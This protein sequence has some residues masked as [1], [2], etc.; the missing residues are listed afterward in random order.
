[1][2][3]DARE[4]APGIVLE[5]DICI[6]G[7]GPAGIVLACELDRSGLSVL[8]LEAGGKRFDRAAEA[9]LHGE[10]AEDCIHCPPQMYRRRVLGGA[11]SIWGGRCVP[12]DPLDL[13][14]RPHV[15]HS[16]WPIGWEELAAFYPRAQTYCE[17][18]AFAYDVAEALGP[19]APPAIEGFFDPDIVD[20]RV[21]RFS[22][23]TDFGQT[24]GPRLDRSMS[25]RVL[26][27][28]QAVR[29]VAPEPAGPITAL[30][31][32][33]APGRR[34]TVR[35]Q[36]YVLAMGG[37]ETPRLLMASDPS[38]RRGGLGNEGGALGRFYMCHIEN[39]LGRLRLLPASRPVALEYER[40][41]DGTYL[42]RKFALSAA[43]QRREGLL[44]TAFRLHY[45]P[46]ADPAHGN[47]VLS[48]M[49]LVK[50]AVLPEYRRKLAAIEIAHRDRLV[51][52]A[53]FWRAH[54]ANVLRDG[55]LGL[56]RFGVD[57]LQRRIL[58]DRK[59]PSVVVRDR[60]GCYPLD[61]NAEQVPNPDSR[62]RLAE[63]AEPDIH[64]VPRLRIE[65]RLTQQDRDSLL[66][67]M[68]LIRDAFAR[69]GCAR[70]EF[71]E[72]AIEAEIGASTPIGGH[73]LGTARMSA[74]PR[75]GVVDP[76][77][78]VHGVP[79][80]YVAGGAVFPTCG[81]AN[82]TL[83]IVALALRLADHLKREAARRPLADIA[84]L[85]FTLESAR[86]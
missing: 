37:L 14:A 39:T 42:R 75:D 35:A 11:S 68:R 51:R 2:I 23:P 84:A 6:V 8:L 49:Y 67:A 29:L 63:A 15:P 74:T 20:S 24:Y 3:L 86:P 55:G 69:S 70:L 7:G 66:R 10:V 18:G 83:T 60:E 25:V 85:P 48:A 1:M 64:G 78:A 65:W 50:D 4:L 46:I 9:A 28:A 40:A 31:A 45:P 57:W 53:R 13:E 82:P 43:A 32:A 41:A 72:A 52:D 81:H 61:V 30:Q 16:G 12:L 59:L 19:G 38:P 73:H 21:E 5:A 71:D 58:A 22:R 79:N 54:I 76:N 44:N 77:C 80:L 36:R 47:A 17:A 56:V 62:V 34:F 26:L 27:H 33:S